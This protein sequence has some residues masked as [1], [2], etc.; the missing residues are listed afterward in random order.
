MGQPNFTVVSTRNGPVRQCDDQSSPTL[1][2]TLS[3]RTGD[4]SGRVSQ[5]LVGQDLVRISTND[6][7]RKGHD[8]DTTREA[9]ETALDRTSFANHDMVLHS[10]ELVSINDID[11]YERIG[12]DSTTFGLRSPQLLNSVVHSVPRLTNLG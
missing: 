9:K 4:S 2:V 6:N 10:G 3:G 1:H 7:T 12:V 11:S 8:Q 5:S